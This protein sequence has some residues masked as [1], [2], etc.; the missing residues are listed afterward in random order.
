[1]HLGKLSYM[2]TNPIVKPINIQKALDYQQLTE[3][4]LKEERSS[5]NKREIND[6]HKW[7]NE[8][9]T[10]LFKNKLDI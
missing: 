3:K 1:M 10:K 5:K 7:G 8:Y 6:M 9:E 4:Q 2:N